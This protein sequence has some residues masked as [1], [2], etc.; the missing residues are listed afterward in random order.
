[1]IRPASLWRR[2]AAL[3][4]D[5]FPLFGI[6]CGVV[7]LTMGGAYLVG[8][9]FTQDFQSTIPQWLLLPLL[10]GSWSGFYIGFWFYKKQTIGMLAWRIQI[11]SITHSPPTIN[12][13]LIRCLVATL[14]LTLF[15]AGYL[16]M[17]FD[18]QK[19][20]WHDIASNT[21]VIHLDANTT[22]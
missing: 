1:M 22:Y 12:Q 21:K 2:L 15:G 20:T 5:I 8:F 16:W 13:L 14:S 3:V 10:I 19:R 11:Q 4:Y 18:S 17:L 7:A 6:S 9:E